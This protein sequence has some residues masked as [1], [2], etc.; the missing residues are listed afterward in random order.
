L[1]V[2]EAQVAENFD[3]FKQ[4]TSQGEKM[5]DF[6]TKILGLAALATAF[7]GLSY[8]Q[9]I[10]C[11]AFGTATVNPTLRS[12]SETELVA[13]A[14]ATCAT[15]NATTFTGSVYASLSLPVTSKAETGNNE[16]GTAVT[17][18]SDAV[19]Q[20]VTGGVTTYYMGTVTGTTVAFTGVTFPATAAFT[21]E[22]SNVR[23]NAAVASAPQVTENLLVQYSN[24]GISQNVTNPTP[25]NVGYVLQSLSYSLAL[26][27]V[28]GFPAI[29]SFS[30]CAGNP[31]PGFGTLPPTANFTVIL[32]EVTSNA[33]KLQAGVGSEQGSLVISNAAN[34]AA[35][36]GTAT[37]PTE[38]QLA[39]TNVPTAATIYL[40]VSVTSNGTTLSL[41]GSVSALTAPAGLVNLDTTGVYGF[42]PTATGTLNV[43]YV[44]TATGAVS[45]TS[46]NIPVDVIVAASAAPVQTTAM[47]VLA[48]YV[49]E[50]AVTGP[51]TL[52][53]TF[54]VS[55]ATP[56]N[57]IT[58]SA[59]QT[60]LLFPYVTNATGFETGIAISNTTTDNL[61]IL[62][63]PGS[64]STPTTGTCTL[65]FYGN[66][67]QPT[68]TV[69]PTL[70]AYSTTAPTVVPVYANI[71]TTMVGSS[72][73][74]GYAIA[75]CNFLEAHGF[76]FITD[77]SGT[78]SG[79]EGYLAVVIPNGRGEGLGTGE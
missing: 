77:T 79:T 39:F 40:P 29:T 33:F 3:R 22:V 24:A 61:K 38:I 4:K 72:G 2:V 71:L 44:T 23:V 49:P 18:N 56:T 7:A 42:T 13:D 75:Q 12:E 10:T 52:I 6:R 30:T 63:A 32:K 8:G 59:C 26:S 58:V 41:Q 51:A 27:A 62:P 36:T 55:T 20:L 28:T 21:L 78:F 54:A 16:G 68:A 35:N 57:T 70:G 67:A 5:S 46:F 34:L 69:T 19:L 47:T 15:T 48:S 66:A 25:L 37:Q 31:I 1:V 50:A 17:G 45:G 64:L 43:V 65:N 60:T 73:F 9:T 11:S 14:T 76:A 74:T 53:P